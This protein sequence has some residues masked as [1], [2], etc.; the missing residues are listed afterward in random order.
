MRTVRLSTLCGSITNHQMSAQG[1]P[2]VNK[3]EQV[4]GHGHGHQLSLAGGWAETMGVRLYGE[5][6][7]IMG[8]DRMGISFLSSD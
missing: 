2:K 1:T 4:S 3:F 6:Q 7:C 5:V 8:D